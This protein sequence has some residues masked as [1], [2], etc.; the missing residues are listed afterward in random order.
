MFGT[1]VIALPSSHQG[2]EVVLAH[3]GSTKTFSTSQ[4]S[5]FGVSWMAWYSDVTHEVKPVTAGRRV[6]LTYNLVHTTGITK[7]SAADSFNQV[8][9]L[10]ML[11][12][13]WDKNPDFVAHDGLAYILEHKYSD[14]SICFENLKGRDQQIVNLLRNASADDR[15]FIG[16]ANI[17]HMVSGECDEGYNVYD[18]SHS[19]GDFHEIT[20]ELDRS[21]TC[22]RVVD[23]DGNLL[24][25]D[26]VIDERDF[27]E[28][29]PFEGVEP[30][31]EDYEGYTGNAGTSATHFYRRTVSCFQ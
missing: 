19:T 7:S 31:H 2:G 18:Y 20:E 25:T 14:A 13:K 12:N 8:Q 23:L 6:V 16:L 10:K 30:D 4:H 11:L 29:N 28:E 17:E 1:L 24:A 3:A 26:L 15:H 5:D 22:S 21:L 9:G 27:V